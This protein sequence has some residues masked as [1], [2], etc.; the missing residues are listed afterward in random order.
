MCVL[1]ESLQQLLVMERPDIM[2][3]VKEPHKGKI[4]CWHVELLLK[5]H[6]IWSHSHSYD[7]PSDDQYCRG[8]GGVGT[9]IRDIG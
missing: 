2:S 1:Q 4:L 3:I 8:T 6:M 7:Q 5:Y 9:V